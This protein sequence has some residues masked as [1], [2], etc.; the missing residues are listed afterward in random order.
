MMMA[1]SD[2]FEYVVANT[3]LS[4]VL[5]KEVLFLYMKPSNICAVDS[6]LHIS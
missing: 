2:L 5:T 1:T 3:A 4:N 6:G